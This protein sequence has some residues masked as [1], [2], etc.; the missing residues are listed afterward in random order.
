MVKKADN[1]SK[2]VS[3]RRA[4]SPKEILSKTYEC[5][6][7]GPR[8]S[9]PFGCPDVN[10]LWFVSGQSASGKSSFVMQLAYELC[11]YGRVLYLSY[12]EG[13]NKSY[14]ERIERFHMEEKQGRF[15]AAI[16]DTLEEIFKRLSRPK[17]PHFVIVD[18]FQVADWTYEQARSLVTTFPRKSFIFVSQEYKGQ[19]MGKPAT[20]LRYLAGVKV[21]VVGFKAF[22]QG[23]FTGDP[24]SYFVVWEEG[25]LRTSNNL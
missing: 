6:P 25:V 15:R 10:E 18:S 1:G 7:W 23:R 2:E 21:R 5:I 8:W 11:N 20:R 16:D 13:V 19:P 12:E 17:S 24:G 3:F 4:Y 22:C 14:R 9:A